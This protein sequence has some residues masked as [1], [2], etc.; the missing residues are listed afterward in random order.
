[1][2]LAWLASGCAST[3]GWT[4]NEA[5]TCERDAAPRVCVQAEPD[6]GHVLTLGDIELLPGECV[7]AEGGGGALRV[8]T[9]NPRDE[10]RRAWVPVRR[11]RITDV[12]IDE[13]GR[14]RAERERCT[15]N[16]D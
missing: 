3:Q 13:R 11:G 10:E 1:L 5:R 14:V 7:Q 12:A 15:I 8:A 4:L 16:P 2:V 9:R 6:H